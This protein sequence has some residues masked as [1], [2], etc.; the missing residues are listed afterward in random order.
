ML[1]GVRFGL[2]QKRVAVAGFSSGF[3]D[4]TKRK[5]FVIAKGVRRDAVDSARLGELLPEALRNREKPIGLGC[6]P[7]DAFVFPPNIQTMNRRFGR[8]NYRSR[9]SRFRLVA[10]N[11]RERVVATGSGPLSKQDTLGIC[12]ASYSSFP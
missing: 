11:R 9:Y 2:S 1:F 10:A 4:R 6:R 7:K 5:R 8:C 3:W 12:C